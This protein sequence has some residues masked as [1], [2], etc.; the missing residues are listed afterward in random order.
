MF[1][2]RHCTTHVEVSAWIKSRTSWDWCSSV[3]RGSCLMVNLPVL[4]N[5]F[6]KG[7]IRNSPG[8]S[9]GH[10]VVLGGDSLNNCAEL[11]SILCGCRFLP[12]PSSSVL[13]LWPAVLSPLLLSRPPTTRHHHHPASPICHIK[14]SHYKLRQWP[15][16]EPTCS[17]H[18][19]YIASHGT[20]NR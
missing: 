17:C 20:H 11:L 18:H 3:W 6:N 8:P 14:G 15:H 13:R 2:T 19:I 1:F 10:S 16:P 7:L 9:A 12:P 5:I 4:F